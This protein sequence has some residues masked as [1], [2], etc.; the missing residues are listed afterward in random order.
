M[1]YTGK[2]TMV[3][4]MALKGSPYLSRRKILRSTMSTYIDN[5][6]QL[7]LFVG[8]IA[9]VYVFL[10]FYMRDYLYGQMFKISEEYLGVNMWVKYFQV[11]AISCALVP[12]HLNVIQEVI[13]FITAL[14]IHSETAKAMA[15]YKE[16]IEKNQR[17]LAK[18]EMD[19]QNGIRPIQASK[20]SRMPRYSS[21]MPKS[22]VSD[23][24]PSDNMLEVKDSQRPLRR[25][26]SPRR[27]RNSIGGGG[28]DGSI[29]PRINSSRA[30]QGFDTERPLVEK[31]TELTRY[32]PSLSQV[33]IQ[34]KPEPVPKVP[35][36]PE[37]KPDA[38]GVC[39]TAFAHVTNYS[40]VSELGNL[41][42]VIFD[43]TDTLTENIFDILNLSTWK[44][45]YKV[46]FS[47]MKKVKEE[48]KKNPEAHRSDTIKDQKAENEDD[49]YSE[50][51][52]E[53]DCDLNFDISAGMFDEDPEFKSV[54]ENI[55]LPF[56]MPV[57]VGY[58][59]EQE[60]RAPSRQAS[61]DEFFSDDSMISREGSKGGR[62]SSKVEEMLISKGKGRLDMA[63]IEQMILSH[64]KDPHIIQ[65]EAE[66]EDLDDSD[67]GNEPHGIYDTLLNSKDFEAFFYDNHSRA[68]EVEKLV[69]CMAIF[70]FCGMVS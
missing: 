23:G 8:M 40:T 65:N 47:K 5:I 11:L 59:E 7:M 45:T 69:S 26:V 20:K 19:I 3:F 48:F 10:S 57:P 66:G 64:K 32:D 27:R 43:K 24:M 34:M 15:S 60:N 35:D 37:S 50:K 41:D 58:A 17:D 52:Q 18:E 25:H 6:T 67:D 61:M 55:R 62:M 46:A 2:D 53:M 1:L 54:V 39:S 29:T 42:H 51:S 21:Y 49:F 22:R 12:V 28:L 44:R 13:L 56:Y 63:K 38:F 30:F 31:S 9:S 70:L 33:P 68:P 16:Q 36:E 4:H 14:M